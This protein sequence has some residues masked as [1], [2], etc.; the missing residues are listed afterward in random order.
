MPVL[1][2]MQ[3]TQVTFSITLILKERITDIPK[4]SRN[5]I[6]YLI[7]QVNYFITYMFKGLLFL[8][9]DMKKR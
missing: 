4:L 2:Q 7:S 8:T 9:E 3:K 5:A 6:G 1:F